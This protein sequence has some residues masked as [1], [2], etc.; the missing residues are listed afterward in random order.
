LRARVQVFLLPGQARVAQM[1]HLI[2]INLAGICAI[3]VL[4]QPGTW[5][6]TEAGPE[7]YEIR[8]R[9]STQRPRQSF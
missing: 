5:R 3:T 9:R 4:R 7:A 6:L 8:R 2:E 1:I